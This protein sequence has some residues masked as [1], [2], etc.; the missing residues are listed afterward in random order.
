MALFVY[1]PAML[2]PGDEV[3]AVAQCSTMQHDEVAVTEG[4]R[5]R[6]APVRVEGREGALHLRIAAMHDKAG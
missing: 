5:T 3:A 4:E 2:E 6:Q 1:V